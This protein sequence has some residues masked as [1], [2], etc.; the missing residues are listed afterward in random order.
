MG[1]EP[2]HPFRSEFDINSVTEIE[3]DMRKLSRTIHA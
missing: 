3:N 1:L 2:A